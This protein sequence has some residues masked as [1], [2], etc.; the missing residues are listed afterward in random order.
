MR[1][2]ALW[3]LVRPSRSDLSMSL[4]PVI[5]FAAL[6]TIVFVVAALA[7]VFWSIPDDGS[8]GYQILAV[9][10]LAVLLVPVTTLGSSAA[11]LSARRRDERLATVRL[12][13]ATAAWVRGVALVE[14]SM[15]AAA[16]VLLG[17]LGYAVV[18]PLLSLLVVAGKRVPLD[19]VWLPPL[20]LPVLGVSVI[21]VA[22]ISAVSGLRQVV[23]SPLGVRARTD[24][25][26]LHWLRLAVSAVV[27]VAAI[28]ILQL[29]SVSW[30]AIGITAA[31]V[32]VLVAVMVV[33]N[34]AGPFVV[35]VLARRKL[36]VASNA[37]ELIAA[38]GLLESPKSAWRQVS[39]V[40]LTSF[41]VVPAG[42]V[43]GFLHTVENSVTEL[44][45]DQVLFFGDI[46]TIVLAAVAVAFLL[47]ACS[48]G[49]VQTAAVL[50]R[51]DLY[52]SL[53][54][55]GMSLAVMQS[56]QRIAV[57]LPLKVA[58]VGSSVLA[59]ALVI[60]V[61]AVALFT[62]PLFV[63]AIVVS[64]VAG[65]WLVRL[66]LTTTTPVLRGVLAHPDRVM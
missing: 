13:G 50:E 57:M 20:L 62:S 31:I 14:A 1:S 64:I 5:A 3:L 28:V 39:G 19:A 6:G 61:M 9:A 30:G 21:V 45:A 53:D 46:R 8:D 17:V 42:A 27:V 32:V 43:L 24:A 48:V 47:V 44:S 29:T 34:V 65:V 40:A 33:Q 58:A 54:R 56:S 4:L 66:G 59:F 63:L 22:V 16:G 2:R 37:G 52:V 15:L 36:A 41:V 60:P 49:I 35:G 25:P 55:I 12:L 38:R 10:L 26:R 7:R 18:T 51:R 23:I 11:R